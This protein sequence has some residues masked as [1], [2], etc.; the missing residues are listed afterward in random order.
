MDLRE[1][2]WGCEQSKEPSG[3]IKRSEFLMWLSG[4]LRWTQLVG[5]VIR[6]IYIIIILN[7]R[8]E[9]SIYT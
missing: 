7:S 1:I 3:S 5:L 9:T 4:F 6:H 8:A 2:E